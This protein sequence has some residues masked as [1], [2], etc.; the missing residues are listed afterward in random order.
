MGSLG[1][2]DGRKVRFIPPSGWVGCFADPFAVFWFRF[3]FR[4]DD[5]NAEFFY[6]GGCVMRKP[7]YSETVD[8]ANLRSVVK[9]LV[10]RLV[11]KA[12]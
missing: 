12:F 3:V 7:D 11:E 5:K 4:K 9:V 8:I 10:N 6:I 1:G 2:S